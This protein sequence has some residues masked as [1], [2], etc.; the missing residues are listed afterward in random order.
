MISGVDVPTGK[1]ELKCHF[2]NE[3]DI[4]GGPASVARFVN[5]EHVGTGKIEKQDCG[6]SGVETLDV[7]VDALTPVSKAY[8]HNR[9]FW[10]SGTCEKVRFD[11]GDKAISRPRKSRV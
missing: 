9:P 11:F 8:E 5:G 10:F 6:R 7:S 1:V 2:I 3:T 4:P